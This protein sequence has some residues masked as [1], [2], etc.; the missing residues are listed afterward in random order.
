M[1]TSHKT[2]KRAAP[3]AD[4]LAGLLAPNGHKVRVEGPDVILTDAALDTL[5]AL[6]DEHDGHVDGDRMWIG[7]T[8]YRIV[9]S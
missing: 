5:A 7:G 4:Q 1:F 2:V 3:Y 6:D 9:E 8:D